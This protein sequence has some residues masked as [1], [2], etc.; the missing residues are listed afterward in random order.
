MKRI[1]AVSVSLIF[2]YFSLFCVDYKF[3]IEPFF[4]IRNG[5][6]YEYVY[7][8]LPNGADYKLSQLEWNINPAY[9][10][11]GTICSDFGA[12]ELSTTVLGLNRTTNGKLY[13]WDYENFDGK[14][15]KFSEHTAELSNSLEASGNIAF[16]FEFSDNFSVAPFASINY[17]R[18]KFDAY[19]GYTQYA[20]GSNYWNKDIPKQELTG[21]LIS[22]SNTM[23]Y[24]AA[25]FQI[26]TNIFNFISIQAGFSASPYIFANSVDQHWLRNVE[27][28]DT[29]RKGYGLFG[30]LKIDVSFLRYHTISI[31]ANSQTIQGVK[32][33]STQRG[34]DS[35]LPPLP[36][37]KGGTANTNFTFGI[38]YKLTID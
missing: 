13:D 11:G 28:I 38:S 1:I 6:L 25:G 14:P 5:T 20:T 26:K 17:S 4:G 12:I 32:G 21:K 37:G 22:Y 19:N 7:S 18:M 31:F 2:F 24:P 34:I 30:D 16:R 36:N 9:L 15:T 27:F 3:S 33:K 29:M 8:V 10:M 23:W 35:N